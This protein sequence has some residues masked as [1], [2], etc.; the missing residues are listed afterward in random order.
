MRVVILGAVLSGLGGLLWGQAQSTKAPP[1]KDPA[2]QHTITVVFDYDFEKSP[3]C[4]EKPTL[5]KCVRQFVVYDV[6][7]KRFRLFSFPVP[8]GA[9][10]FVKGIKA[11]SPTRIFLP[12]KHFIAVTAQNAAGAESNPNAAT[13]AVLVK[14]KTVESSSP[15]K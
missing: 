14:P 5:K 6:S 9:R 15:A 1:Q 2:N 12:G 8:E 4:A 3:S 10:G 11:E 7:G 13:T